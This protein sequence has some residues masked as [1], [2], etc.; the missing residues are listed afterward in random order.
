MSNLPAVMQT[1]L[2]AHLRATDLT[3]FNDEAKSGIGSGFMSPPRISTRGSA[4]RLVIDGVETTLMRKDEEGNKVK[5]SGINVVVVGTNRGKYKTYYGG[6]KY[7]PAAEGEAPICYSYD[8]ETPSPHASTPQCATCAACPNNVFGSAVT[9]QGN[10]TRACSDNKLIAVIDTSAITNKMEPGTLQGNVYQMK[11][12]PT[13]L[14][15]NKE[16]RKAAPDDNTSWLE[17]VELMNNLPTPEGTVKVAIPYVSVRLSFDVNANYPL[18]RYKPVRFLTADEVEQVKLRMQGEDVK[19]AVSEVFSDAPPKGGSEDFKS[20]EQVEAARVAAAAAETA[21]V[22]AARQKEA[23]RVAAEAEAAR[24]KAA[25]EAKAAAK[26][27]DG[28]GFVMGDDAR[29][30]AATPAAAKPV[31]PAKPAKAAAV[32]APVA[33]KPAA[34]AKQIISDSEAAEIEAMFNS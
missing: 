34:A 16:T 8:G 32:A 18:V 11:V 12:P 6:K 26:D 14:S 29:E 22:A 21:R 28:S 31:K 33:A 30:Y 17:F 2:P 25:D 10:K 24:V 9:E 4:F 5:A 13:G 20:P 3:A 27:E 7:D 19:A 23:A 15:R 1:Q